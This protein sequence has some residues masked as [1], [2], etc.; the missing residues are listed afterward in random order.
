M[1]TFTLP[2]PVPS[3]YED[4]EH[5][6]KACHGWGTDE[7]AIIDVLAHRNAAQRNQIRLAFEEQ[8][9]EN[10]IK[11]L[12]SELTGDFERA[13]YRW[14]FEPIEREAMMAKIALKKKLDYQV[15]IEIACV[16]SPKELLA[17]KDAYQAR[18]KHCLEED[19]AAHAAGDFR[20]LLVALVSTYRYDGEEID[21][22]L[23]HSE[24][25]TI[26]GAIEEG[27]G[28]FDHSEIIRILS[29]RSKAQLRATFNH[30]KDEYGVSIT[31]AFAADPTNEF[32]HA[33]RTAIRCIVSPYKYFVKVLRGAVSGKNTDEDA[34]TRIV[35][36]HAEKDLKL[37]K[38]KF[39]ERT[40]VT[41]EDAVGN[42][43]SGDYR[44]FLL[45]LIGN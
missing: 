43:T 30:Y 38:E 32:A 20:Q 5:I 4:A 27:V 8:H 11:R 42:E 17:V 21:M 15:I 1:A 13:V 12:E 22:G 31:K 28:S 41:L 39:Y 9:N 7:K 26:Q 40:N 18:Y 29:T 45:A 24:A 34:L 37:I 44:A 35:V 14:I 36:M 10:L 19:V 25:K 33:L 3:P 6:W 23:A 16:N 2:D